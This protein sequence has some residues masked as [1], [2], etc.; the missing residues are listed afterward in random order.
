MKKFKKLKLPDLGVGWLEG[1]K[2]NI[3][4]SEN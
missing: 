2:E 4:K 3:N 1:F